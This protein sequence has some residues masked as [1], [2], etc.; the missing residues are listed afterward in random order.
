MP[1]DHLRLRHPVRIDAIER[2]EDQ[3][4]VIAHRA[5]AAD[6]RVEHAEVFAWNVDQFAGLLRPP[7]PRRGERRNARASGLEQFSSL[8]IGPPP[9]STLFSTPSLLPEILAFECASEQ[10]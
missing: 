10:L 9:G 2:I 6:D 4:G 5:G 8:L 1:L 7:D 3:I